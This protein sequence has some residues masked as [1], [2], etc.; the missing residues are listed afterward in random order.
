MNKQLYG[1]LG[2]PLV[3]SFSAHYFAEKFEREHI[4]AEYKNF[5]YANVDE[6]FARFDKIAELKGF[7]VTIPHKQAVMT[8]LQAL[9]PEAFAIGAVN[10]V[11]VSEDEAGRRQYIGCNSDVIGFA[12]SIHP[13]IAPDK[14]KRA[15]ILGTGGASKAVVY[16][17]RQMGIKPQY[18]SRSQRLDTITYDQLTPE[19]MA[20][21]K[22]VVNCS[23]VGMYPHT[24]ESPAIP[25]HLLTSDHLLYDLVYNPLETLFMKRGAEQGATVKNGLEMLHLQAE[26]AWQMWHGEKVTI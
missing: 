2:Y 23:P 19:I 24:D 21:H 16:A 10:V 12:R 22:V 9:S 8:H 13:L 14:H 6:A 26:A 20:S 7:N 18:V 25:Y 4:E 15:L 3:H 17:L 11:C 5:E 1:L